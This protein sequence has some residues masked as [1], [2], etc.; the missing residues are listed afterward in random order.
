MA[1]ALALL[2]QADRTVHVFVAL[3]DNEHQG[4]VPVPAALGNGKDPKNN[5]YWGAK[6][7]VK[8]WLRKAD[9]WTTAEAPAKPDDPAVLERARFVR[10][11]MP[12]L[13]VTADAYNGASMKEALTDFFA[14]AAGK[15][16]RADLV[17]FVGHNGLMDAPL[18]EFPL[19]D[20]KEGPADAIVLAC[21]SEAYFAGPLSKAG[22]RPLLTTRG[23]M[24]PEAYTLEAALTSWARGE[25]PEQVR[26]TA[27]TAYD[28]HQKC[29]ARAAERLF[30]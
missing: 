21:K 16:P 20:G 24:A 27:A 4:I 15:G 28:R 14:A 29:G 2:I 11:G 1:L 9:G 10:E 7:G 8:S 3:C 18:E 19:R 17:A 26:A 25:T 12:R 6:Y 30:R 22:C 13:V 5:L 23:L